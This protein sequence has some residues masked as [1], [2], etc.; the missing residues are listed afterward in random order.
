[1]INYGSTLKRHKYPSKSSNLL[2]TWSEGQLKVFRNKRPSDKIHDLE[3]WLEWDGF[4]GVQTGS[5]SSVKV[6]ATTR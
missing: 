6:V 2:H 1:M 3:Q 5:K 4:E